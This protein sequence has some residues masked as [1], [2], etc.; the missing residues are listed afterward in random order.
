MARVR[1]KP[2]QLL[3]EALKSAGAAARNNILKTSALDRKH[4]EIL[5]R[6]K[7]LSEIIQGWYLLTV[8]A[9]WGESTAWFGSFWDFL[10]HYLADRFGAN[11]YCLSAESSLN[12]LTGETTVPRQIVVL[13]RKASNTTINFPHDTSLLLLVDKTNFPTDREKWEGLW[14]MRL[15]YALCRVTP[16]YYSR[17]PRAIEIALKTTGLSVADISRTI[18]KHEAFAGGERIIGAYRHLGE[19]GKAGQIRGD[20]IAAGYQVKEVDPFADY[21]PCLQTVRSLSPYAG[22]IRAMWQEM[23]GGVA[24]FMPK[25]QP[26]MQGVEE[27]ITAIKDKYKA[28]AHNSLSIEG[29]QVTPELIEKI[30]SGQWAPE[31][32]AG[33][34]RQTDV[35]AAQGYQQAFQVVL[36]SIRRVAEQE[37][38]GV[39][40]EEDLQKWYRQ[41]FAPFVSANLLKAAGLAGYRDQ[42]VYI[43][44][45]RH[46]PPPKAAVPDCMETLFELLKNEENPVV[47]AVLGHFVFVFIHPYMDGN[48]RIGRFLMNLM[49]IAAGCEWTI[50]RVEHRE[51]YLAALEE[52]ATRGNIQP[53]A[54]FIKSEMDGI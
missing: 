16:A 39:V 40:F 24:A 49:M 54:E 52:A 50:I 13:T 29:Y 33:D 26:T 19:E 34:R 4:R 30:A 42:R 27:I 31:N 36:E 12:L 47:G 21:E 9:G 15:P 1:T 41:M 48:G 25:P 44:G 2:Q 8:P 3:A 10:R 17:N 53:L 14:V 6:E 18:F 35:L 22:R 28:D 37:N 23:R 38:P 46:V 5:L 7:Y 20:L 45:A 32:D 51:R 11:G 43:R